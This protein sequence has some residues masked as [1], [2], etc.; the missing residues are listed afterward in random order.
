VGLG[1][2]T[3]RRV[4]RANSR[5]RRK[6]KLSPQGCGNTAYYLF[7]TCIVELRHGLPGAHF[8]AKPVKVFFVSFKDFGIAFSVFLFV[9]LPRWQSAQVFRQPPQLLCEIDELICLKFLHIPYQRRQNY[10]KHFEETLFNVF[11]A[12][13]W[14]EGVPSVGKGEFI[15]ILYPDAPVQFLSN[16]QLAFLLA[17]YNKVQRKN[18]PKLVLSESVLANLERKRDDREAG[19]DGR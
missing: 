1:R 18:T 5:L 7:S 14:A 3:P 10:V 8:E 12:K 13:K 11:E 16:E 17:E 15:C 9:N 19:I 6:I 4:T 2:R